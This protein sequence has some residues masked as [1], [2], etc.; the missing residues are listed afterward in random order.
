VPHPSTT[1]RGTSTLRDYRPRTVWFTTDDRP[2]ENSWWTVV[3]PTPAEWLD[4]PGE[5][6]PDGDW[7]GVGPGVSRLHASR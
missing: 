2:C 7:R 4:L 5:V 1:A 3:F 6:G